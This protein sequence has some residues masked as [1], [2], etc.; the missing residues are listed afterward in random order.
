MIFGLET[1]R[2]MTGRDLSI[3]VAE[4]Y[5]TRVEADEVLRRHAG[6]DLEYAVQDFCARHAM[7]EIPVTRAGR[8]D[9]VIY[10]IESR[11]GPVKNLGVCM[12]ATI[13]AP[14][15]AGLAHLPLTV[16]RRAWRVA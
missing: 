15:R 13:A 6:G 16:A 11:R 12:G 2:A 14:S 1:T 3:P 9:L 7:P 4:G 8:G 5:A 10:D